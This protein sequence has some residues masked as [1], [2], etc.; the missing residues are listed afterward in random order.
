MGGPD[1][2]KV[3]V[4]LLQRVGQPCTADPSLSAWLGS[5]HCRGGIQLSQGPSS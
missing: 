1:I 3:Y 5:S 2:H 4:H